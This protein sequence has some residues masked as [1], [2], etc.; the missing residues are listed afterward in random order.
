MNF[1]PAEMAQMMD[2]AKAFIAVTMVYSVG[3][4]IVLGALITSFSGTTRA[5]N[6]SDL[7]CQTFLPCRPF[8]LPRRPFLSRRLTQLRR[9]ALD[10]R[11]P[12]PTT[13][14]GRVLINAQMSGFGG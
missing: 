8:L 14:L 9:I 11:R 1:G 4:G 10:H 5:I 13:C 2:A 3:I 7:E 6:R 12:A